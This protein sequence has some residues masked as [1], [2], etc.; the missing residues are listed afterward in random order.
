MVQDRGAVTSAVEIGKD[1]KMAADGHKIY[2]VVCS[3][4]M[5]VYFTAERL[6]LHCIRSNVTLSMRYAHA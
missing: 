5:L 4:N 6:K 1:T 2:R 3:V